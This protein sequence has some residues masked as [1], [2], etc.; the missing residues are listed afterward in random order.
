MS[1]VFAQGC[2]IVKE[3]TSLI[4]RRYISDSVVFTPVVRSSSIPPDTEKPKLEGRLRVKLLKSPSHLGHFTSRVNRP[5][6]EDK[7]NANVLTIRDKEVFNFNIFDGHGGDQCSKYLAENLSL[8]VECSDEMVKK[9]KARE[10]LVKKYAKNVGGY[11]KRWYKHREKTF[12][13]WQASKLPIKSFKKDLE[14]NDIAFRLPL[15]F[16]NTDYEFFQQEQESGSTCT[17]AFFQTIYNN[18]V[19]SLPVIENYYFNR[20]TISLLTIAHVGDT[21]AILVD[22]NGIANALTVDHHPSNPLESKRLRRYAANFFM[23]DS[24]GEERFIALANT[25]AFGDVSYKEMGVTAEPEV[26]QLIVGDSRE[27]SQ[28]LTEDEI[29][30]YTVGG[31][32][33]DECFLIL[34]TDGVTNVLTDQEIADIIMTHYKRQGHV[35]ATPQFCA[36]EVINFVE[37]VG[38]DDNATILVIRLNGWGN[39]P[40]IDRTGE[41]RQ[42]RLDDY[43]PRR[44][45]G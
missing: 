15:S 18:P 6:N 4:S 26:T 30:K 37:Y 42:Q 36:Q 8:N 14:K 19:K 17:S 21:R 20:N 39:W 32:G 11:W 41:L 22:K 34:C 13:T 24:F 12:A 27:I 9:K 33:G 3:R 31:L 45:S 10:D 28:K 1:I 43:N 29:K 40:N 2:R 5:Y 44:N 16:L 23:T 7:Y 38:G 25:R 35:K